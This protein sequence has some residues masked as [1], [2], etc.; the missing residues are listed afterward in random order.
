VAEAEGRRLVR[1]ERRG[2]VAVVVLADPAARNALSPALA[3]QL[4][5][6]F[7]ELEADESVFA[8]VV[9]GEPPAFCGGA[10]LRH[11][12][13]A[14][15]QGLRDVYAGFLRVGRCPLPTVAAV[16][17]AAVGAGMNLALACDVRLAGPRARF[18][19]R[20]MALGL[21]PGGGHTFLLRRAVGHQAATAMLLLGQVVTGQ[22]AV[23]LGLAH[24]YVADGDLV[25]EAVRLAGQAEGTP[26][27][28]LMRTKASLTRTDTIRTHDEALAAELPD[29]LWSM[30]QPAFAERLAALSA[31]I[32]A[33]AS[34]RADR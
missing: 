22:D 29:Q 16:G 31:R 28:L 19:T 11:L 1:L 24:E 34:R 3:A 12:G 5:A 33:S 18:D 13:Q 27:E 15:E 26:R 23:R 17:G 2:G 14:D 30:R 9:T 6:V 21:H 8:V 10:D 20:F 7:D 4:V 32:S 25:E